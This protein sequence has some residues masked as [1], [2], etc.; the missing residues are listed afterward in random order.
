[1]STDANSSPPRRRKRTIIPL[2]L[3]TL[4]IVIGVGF[5]VRG[6]WPDDV[7]KNPASVAD[8][9]VTQLYRKPNS[10]V[11]IRCAV[12][13]DAAPKKVWAV[14]TDYNSQGDFVPYVS[15]VVGAKRK[16]GRIQIDGV[17]SSQLWG[18][19]PYESVVTNTEAPD[20]GQYLS[21]WNAVDTDIFKVSRGS[22]QITPHGDKA[23]LLVLTLQVELKDYPNFIV[24]NI[25]MD[26]VHTI[27]K[28]MRDETL[29][30]N[31][32]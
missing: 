27:V 25:I 26:R 17:A 18:D 24:R 9:T 23:A 11:V 20:Q 1:M 8:W 12:V 5:F 14:V 4:L 28:A 22:W 15:K 2:I 13:V 30:R 6:T 29:R 31:Q 3:L 32:S 21:T 16:D 19:W 10:N 7:E